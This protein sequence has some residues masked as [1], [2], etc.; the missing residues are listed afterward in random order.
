MRAFLRS[1]IV[2]VLP[3]LVLTGCGKNYDWHQKLTVEV[4]TPEG[5]KTGSS[6]M[7]ARL[8]DT[9][10][11]FVPAEANVV[12]FQLNGE[13]VAL[14]VSQVRYLFVLLKS[15]PSLNWLVYPKMDSAKAGSL[16]ESG[17]D[18]GAGKVALKPDQYPL[19]VTFDDIN[20]PASV[21]RIDPANL[22][23]TFGPGY[24]L[25]RITLSLTKEPVTKRK[26]EKVLGWLIDVGNKRF[27]LD[28]HSPSLIKDFTPEQLI[29]PAAFLS[30]D[31]WKK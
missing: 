24:R 19:L 25:N 11:I 2:I 20:D 18:G 30:L 3:L 27:Y 5:L 7:S 1:L 23:A 26:V 8:I 16:L 14:E 9:H 22:E 29:T 17:D 21:K 15:V 28:P 6:V 12:S 4:E 31:H 13:A 10:G